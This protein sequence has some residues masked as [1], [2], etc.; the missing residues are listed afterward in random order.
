MKANKQSPN[1]NPSTSKFNIK[2]NK[3]HPNKNKFHA[4]SSMSAPPAP[5]PLAWL[6]LLCIRSSQLMM[7][8][9]SGPGLGGN[10]FLHRSIRKIFCQTIRQVA[11]NFRGDYAPQVENVESRNFV[12]I[13]PHVDGASN[14]TVDKMMAG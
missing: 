8:G 5:L 9:Y 2:Q 3:T 11:K 7:Y 6:F 12:I 1:K 10:I 13:L 4:S 14:E